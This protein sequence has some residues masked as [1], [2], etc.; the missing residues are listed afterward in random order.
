V[1]DNAEPDTS[2]AENRND[3]VESGYSSEKAQ[4]GDSAESLSPAE[5]GCAEGEHSLSMEVEP[6]DALLP[7][8]GALIGANISEALPPEPFT[9]DEEEV[10]PADSPPD[11]ASLTLPLINEIP[12]SPTPS[13]SP[14]SPPKESDE[15]VF[16]P[17][18]NIPSDYVE[19][20]AHPH[21]CSPTES[22]GA[23]GGHSSLDVDDLQKRL[24]SLKCAENAASD[25]STQSDRGGPSKAVPKNARNCSA[26][27]ETLAPRTTVN[28]GECSVLS[29]LNQFTAVEYMLSTNQVGCDNC[30]KTKSEYPCSLFP[31]F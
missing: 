21:D 24:F 17:S 13:P 16:Q 4:I 19:S 10:L 29:C 15:D 8:T 5:S 3:V 2:V 20:N 30:T 6:D 23:A 9:L 18:C 31:L 12:A 22:D 14:E 7:A 25:G 26:W 27:T 1:E 11:P 28:E